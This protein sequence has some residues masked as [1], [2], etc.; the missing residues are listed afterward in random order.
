ASARER[1]VRE[2]HAQFPERAPHHAT[3]ARIDAAGEEV[4]A[5]WHAHNLLDL[6]FC[7]PVREVADDA[8]HAPPSPVEDDQRWDR[9]ISA[10]REPRVCSGNQGTAP[11]EAAILR[12]P[13][14][15]GVSIALQILAIGESSV[16]PGAFEP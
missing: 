11:L 3:G 4:E 1:S 5:V 15:S 2:L 13:D 6:E 12:Q 16:E 9:G 8:V 14:C 10:R 7:A